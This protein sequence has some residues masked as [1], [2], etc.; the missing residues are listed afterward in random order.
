MTPELTAHRKDHSHNSPRKARSRAF[1]CR[2][3]R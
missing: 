3:R 2:A 1:I